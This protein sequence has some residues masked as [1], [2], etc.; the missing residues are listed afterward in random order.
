MAVRRTTNVLCTAFS[1]I[2]ERGRLP[3]AYT[4]ARGKLNGIR[5]AASRWLEKM[6]IDGEW[7]FCGSGFTPIG[8]FVEDLTEKMS[9]R[10]A[11][12]LV[13]VVMV[14]GEDGHGGVFGW[15]L[16]GEDEQWWWRR[17]HL[18]RVSKCLMMEVRR[19]WL[20]VRVAVTVRV[21]DDD[22]VSRVMCHLL[23]T[24][25]VY[26]GLPFEKTKYFWVDF[27]STTCYVLT[28]YELFKGRKPN[29]SYPQIFG[30]KCFFLNNGKESLGKFDS[31]ADEAIFIGYS[32]TSKAYRVYNKRTMC[33]EESIHVFFDEYIDIATNLVHSRKSIDVGDST[34]EEEENEEIPKE[35]TSE[36]VIDPP[37]AELIKEWKTLRNFSTS[38]IIGDITRGVSTRKQLNWFCMNVVFVSKIEPKNIELPLL[39]WKRIAVLVAMCIV[40]VQGIIFQAWRL[41]K[42]DTP[43]KLVDASLGDSFNISE[44]LRCI[45]VGLLCVQLHPD[46]RPHMAY[47]IFMLSGEN[48][49]REPKEPGFLVAR[50]KTAGEC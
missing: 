50:M 47:V 28:P 16:D 49:L 29:I 2:D 17:E 33:V 15:L 12:C 5:R 39:R 46:N 8:F 35:E 34:G 9:S 30:C 45:H 31:K 13:V 10:M 1:P 25:T 42:E 43:M 24:W 11:R 18:V 19:R 41:W 7:C 32:L 3:Y 22:D 26:Q 6:K 36:N 38:N 23:H 48:I 40:V 44:A 21:G 37:R 20:T 4:T 14:E 27:V